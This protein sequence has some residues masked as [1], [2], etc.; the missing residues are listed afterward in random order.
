MTKVY[1]KDFRLKK[2]SSCKQIQPFIVL[3][4]CCLCKDF[5]WRIKFLENKSC[6]SPLFCP[7]RVTL[8]W[9][10]KGLYA[11]VIE[12]T[13]RKYAG[14]LYLY[15]CQVS[16]CHFVS[17]TVGLKNDHPLHLCLRNYSDALVH[18]LKLGWGGN[19]SPAQIILSSEIGHYLDTYKIILSICDFN[20]LKKSLNDTFKFSQNN[21]QD[22]I[23]TSC[24]NSPLASHLEKE[25]LC[26]SWLRIRDKVYHSSHRK[27]PLLRMRSEA[28]F[29]PLDS[30]LYASHC[31]TD[32]DGF[33]SVGPEN[34]SWLQW[35]EEMDCSS[36]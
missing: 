23:F 3:R 14:E 9:G 25:G 27:T 17:A 33:G 35:V 26:L 5:S 13:A 19:F 12:N 32:T 34:L 36:P 7:Y 30:S 10:G 1:W 22:Q 6:N 31:Q 28:E 2:N 24:E 21:L 16:A 11:D 4:G 18:L 15:C 8:L 29:P 20:R